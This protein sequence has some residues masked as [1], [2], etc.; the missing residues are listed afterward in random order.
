MVQ[1]PEFPFSRAQLEIYGIYELQTLEEVLR[2]KGPQSGETRREVARRIQNKIAWEGAEDA[3]PE[4]FL[5]AFYAALRAH[6]ETR[7]LFGERRKDKHAGKN[8]GGPLPKI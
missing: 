2:Q 4:R 1:D 5:K 8:P 6:L 3:D 7:M